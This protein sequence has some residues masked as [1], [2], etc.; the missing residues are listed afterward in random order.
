M[1]RNRTT[2][3]VLNGIAYTLLILACLACTLAFI[4]PFWLFYPD[5]PGVL[6]IVHTLTDYIPKYPFDRASWKGLCAVCFKELPSPQLTGEEASSNPQCVWFVENDFAVQKALPDWYLACQCLYA[7]GLAMF[8][9]AL[10][11]ESFYA[12]CGCCNGATCNCKACH[13]TLVASLTI[14]AGILVSASLAVFAGF[15]CSENELRSVTSGGKG[16]QLWWGFFVAV[17]GV[18]A[19]IL[20]AILFYCDGCRLANIYDNYRPPTV[21]EK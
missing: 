9:L 5:R 18:G 10:L 1:C 21:T 16:G 7:A 6:N 8:L 15:S 20:S 13:P 17:G 12:C 14:T 4:A 11:T 2:V 19:A 3:S